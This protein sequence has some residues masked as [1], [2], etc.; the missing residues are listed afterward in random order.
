MAPRL[1]AGAFSAEALALAPWSVSKASLAR[2]CPL[3][4]HFKYRLRLR[5]A[6]S[7]VTRVGLAAH[8]VLERM[9]RGA[10][11][12]PTLAVVSRELGLA[13]AELQAL[14]ALVPGIEGFCE[15]LERFRSAGRIAREMCEERLG[16]SA[17]LQP[18]AFS[19]A[20]V[21][22]RGTWDLALSLVDGRCLLIDHKSGKK[23]D[24]RYFAD[25][26][27]AYAVLGL[28]HFPELRR[29]WPAIHFIPA[30]EV[31]W[32]TPLSADE[33]RGPVTDWFV[34]W[35]NDAA[36]CASEPDPRPVVSGFCNICS[37]RDRCPAH[38]PP[39]RPERLV[40]LQVRPAG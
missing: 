26:L 29:A 20:G 25:Q 4:F 8:A 35:I 3:A 28:A 12:A 31:V 2:T 30:A 27:R 39:G 37:F 18:K 22:F 15:T 32:G 11:L 24:L 21:F 40:P 6:P 9:E 36:R 33:I 14:R 5:E 10:D 13:T 19:G 7:A 16:L 34:G 38:A 1:T 23:K 17:D